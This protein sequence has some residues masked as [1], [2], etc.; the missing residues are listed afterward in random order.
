MWRRCLVVNPRIPLY[1]IQLQLRMMFPDLKSPT[2][3]LQQL[4]LD[5]PSIFDRVILFDDHSYQCPECARSLYHA[6]LYSLPWLVK[7]PIHEIDLVS[8][9]P[10]CHKP[11]P[12]IDELARR[13]CRVC[14]RFSLYGDIDGDIEII[15]REEF[16]AIADIYTF[17]EDEASDTCPCHLVDR[18][19]YTLYGLAWNH[20][21][22]TPSLG[23][24]YFPSYHVGLTDNS[25]NHETLK[26]LHIQLTKLSVKTSSVL[27]SD[28]RPGTRPIKER[29]RDQYNVMRQIV[30]WIGEKTSRNHLLHISSYRHLYASNVL[31]GPTFC[32]YCMALS[33]WFFYSSCDVYA[34]NKSEKFNDYPFLVPI[35]ARPPYIY[36]IAID[37]ESPHGYWASHVPTDGFSS[38]FYRRGLEVLYI[39][40]LKISFELALYSSNPN[41]I[42]VGAQSSILDNEPTEKYCSYTIKNGK[43]LFFYEHEH[44][45]ELIT[46]KQL[47]HIESQCKRFQMYLYGL[48]ETIFKYQEQILINEFQYQSFLRLH[49]S[50]SAFLNRCQNFDNRE[51][52][53]IVWTVDPEEL[54]NCAAGKLL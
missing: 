10:A 19:P 8:H 2:Q 6:E 44:P 25:T 11:W 47:P 16:Q 37:I 24:K 22:E 13:D 21:W 31:G 20:W 34:R 41:Q 46:P 36:D 33:L 3:R 30:N 27:R 26:R 54:L 18:Q 5:P 52:S 42:F 7:C 35:E 29:L 32:P 17:I 23:S 43:L 53:G 51:R 38:W 28:G 40:L 39:S 45:L 9:C 1:A 12:D 48:R 4:Q 15:H 14:G 50:F 49:R